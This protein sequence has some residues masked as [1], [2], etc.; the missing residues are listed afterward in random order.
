[1]RSTFAEAVSTFMFPMSNE[2]PPWGSTGVVSI[3]V[4]AAR[5]VREHTKDGKGKFG[6]YGK[7]KTG[8]DEGKHNRPNPNPSPS[9]SRYF[10]GECGQCKKWVAGERTVA[11][12]SK[13][14]L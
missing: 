10:D 6:K 11:S 8:K 7:G 1:M 2:S 12:A 4:D 14:S 13:T 5:D 3:Q 9:A